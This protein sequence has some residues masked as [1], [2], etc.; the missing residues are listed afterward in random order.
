MKLIGALSVGVATGVAAI[1]LHL[2]APPV[3]IT[4]S[5]IGTFCAIWALGRSYGKRIYKVIGALGWF[6]IFWKGASLG[7]GNE[8]LIQ[9][10]NL[11][12]LFL[13]FSVAALITAVALPAN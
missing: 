5:I 2:F 13:L 6:A 4:L 7:V 1:F 11:G 10:D 12:N 3:G 9:G 8:V